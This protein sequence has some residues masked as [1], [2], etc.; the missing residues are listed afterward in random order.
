LEY[1]RTHE[2]LLRVDGHR[3]TAADGDI[4]AAEDKFVAEAEAVIATQNEA[5]MAR[6]IAAVPIDQGAKNR[7]DTESDTSA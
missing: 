3:P 6:S 2:Q 1:A 5:W 4:S 7:G